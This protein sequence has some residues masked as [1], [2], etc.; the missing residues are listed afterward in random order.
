MAT[1]Q[2]DNTAVRTALWRALHVLIDDKPFVIEDKIGY[3][4]IKPETGWQDRPDMKYTK[5]SV[6]L[7]LHVH[8]LLKI[9]PKNK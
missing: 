6:L 3:E 5:G 7:L 2:P 8:D 1:V 4:L 9:L